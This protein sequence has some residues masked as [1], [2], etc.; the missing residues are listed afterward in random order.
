MQNPLTLYPTLCIP[1]P[2]STPPCA[3]PPPYSIPP[4]AY[5]PTLFY[6][7][8][9]IPSPHSTPPCS[10]PPPY[11]IPPR[12]YPPSILSHPVHALPPTLSQPMHG[13]PPIL[14]QFMHVLP[15]FYPSPRMLS[16]YSTPPHACPLSILSHPMHALLFYHTLCMSFPVL[17]QPTHATPLFYTILF[18]SIPA[19]AC[20]PNSLPHTPWRHVSPLTSAYAAFE[21]AHIEYII[22]IYP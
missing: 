8:L 22:I 9:C 10:Y 1:S 2:H 15:L 17:Y 19:H 6:P 12:A 16:P 13:S 21:S 11:S 4:R 5:P 7:T 14:C 20:P 18:Y 3:Y